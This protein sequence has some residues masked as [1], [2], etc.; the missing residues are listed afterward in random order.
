MITDPLQKREVFH[1]TFLRA[2]GRSA[3]PSTFVV[4]GGCNLRFFFGSIRYSEDIDLD[5]SGVPVHLLRDR[6]MAILQSSGLV[7]TLRTFGIDR[8][9]PPALSRAKQTETVQR[10]KVHLLTTAGEDLPTKIEFSRRGLDSPIRAEPVSTAIVAAYRLAPVI[11]PHYTTVP[12]AR[13]KIRALIGRR[14]PQARD[15]FDLYTLSSQPE[16]SPADLMAGFSERDLRQAHDRIY[17]IEYEQ[18]RDTVV[19]FLAADDRVTYGSSEV[20]DEI[21]M[22]AASLI[23]HSGESDE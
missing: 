11:V 22:R 16:V 21:R 23:E 10:F 19:S 5:A 8:V 13:Q 6:V 3:P 14:E 2:L 15:V 1:L 17:A 18:Y 4:K 20:W 7:D 9:Q 12:A